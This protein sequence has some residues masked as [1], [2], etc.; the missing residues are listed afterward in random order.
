MNLEMRPY[1]LNNKTQNYAWGTKNEEAFIPKF[2]GIKPEQDVPYAELWIGTHPKAP[3]TITIDNA[4]VSLDKLI[5]QFP[6]EILGANIAPKFNNKLPFLL[7]VLS[8]GQALSIQSHPDKE[9]AK[10]LHAQDPNNYPD[11]NHKPEI[12]IAVDSL[13]A[14]AGFKPASEIKKVLEIYPCLKNYIQKETAEKFES[15]NE[16]KPEAIKA[17]YSDIM[18]TTSSELKEII[19][20]IVKN[21]NSREEKNQSENQFL[22]QHEKYGYDVGLISLLI[23]NIYNLNADEGFFTGAG[24]PHCYIKG[25]IIECMANSDNVIRA[26]LTDKH[27]DVVTLINSLDY[28]SFPEPIIPI[29]DKG[30]KFVYST[31]AEEFEITIFSC[32]DNSSQIIKDNKRLRIILILEGNCKVKYGDNVDVFKSGE[33]FLLP[34]SLQDFEIINDENAKYFSVMVPE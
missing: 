18:N 17:L 14:I 33:V 24:I 4:E 23:F 34:A 1:L 3:S 22:I 16:I 32:T 27:K 8:A 13:I 11:D 9:L 28:E 10:K 21:I 7:K 2:L 6:R 20:E 25:N 26:G 30:N 19:D 29:I 5:A 31:E 12:A 15:G